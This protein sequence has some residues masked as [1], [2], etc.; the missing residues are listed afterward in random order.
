MRT[1]GEVQERDADREMLQKLLR[2]IESG[3]LKISPP[4][5]LSVCPLFVTPENT[6]YC[7]YLLNS[8]RP[9]LSCACQPL[10]LWIIHQ[11][12]VMMETTSWYQFGC[13]SL[14]NNILSYISSQRSKTK[15]LSATKSPSI[16]QPR[17]GH[18]QW[19][20]MKTLPCLWRRG[21]TGQPTE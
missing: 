9:N 3:P 1:G 14:T 2:P 6:F 15:A 20:G 4:R 17:F 13:E 12:N 16:K 19:P 11:Y 10:L 21:M 7:C 18:L 5:R 8:P